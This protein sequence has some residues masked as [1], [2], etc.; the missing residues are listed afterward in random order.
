M[1][2]IKWDWDK[3]FGDDDVQG[4][5]W[6]ARGMHH[7]LIGL[8]MQQEPPGSLPDD[9]AAI[10]RRLGSPSD[11]VW[12]RVKPQIF[13]AWTLRDGRW[14]QKGTAEA[15]QQQR[16]RNERGRL[17][18]HAKQALSSQQ[19]PASPSLL[20]GFQ[21]PTVE[22]VKGYCLER[23]NRVNPEA[24]V[25]FYSSKGW[26]VGSAAMKDWRAA[27]RTWEGRDESNR[28]GDAWMIGKP[29]DGGSRSWEDLSEEERLEM[30]RET[31]RH[32]WKIPE[33]MKPYAERCQHEEA[34][35]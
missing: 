14:F 29:G 16:A 23:K 32:K 8:S 33:F 6:E 9:M 31:L 27:V 34:T 3:W 35:A 10:R 4:M 24:F 22:E 26:K 12:R 21:V 1:R 11:D 25:N 2:E 18:G 7:H 5:D 19:A 30:A 13:A 28:P 15:C 20:R 17:G